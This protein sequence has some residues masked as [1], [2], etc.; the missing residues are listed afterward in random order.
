M[1]RKILGRL[2]GAVLREISWAGDC[3]LIDQ[4][5]TPQD[6]PAISGLARADDNI[7]ALSREIDQ[8]VALTEMKI[9]QW[10]AVEEVGQAGKQ[11]ISG[12]EAMRVDTKQ[13]SGLRIFQHPFGLIEVG[14]DR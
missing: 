2:R 4:A 1:P 11:E 7:V 9:D 13:T 8:P 5:K 12:D 6:Q 3:S 10:I 14:E